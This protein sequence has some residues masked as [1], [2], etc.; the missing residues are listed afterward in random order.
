MNHNAKRQRHE[1]ARKQHKHDHEHNARLAAKQPRS[2][3]PRWMLIG[4]VAL[5]FAFVLAVAFGR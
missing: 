5:I 4:G 3:F 2:G 1:Q